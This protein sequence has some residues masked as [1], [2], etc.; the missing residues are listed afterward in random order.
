MIRCMYRAEERMKTA[1]GV[2][3]RSN[4]TVGLLHQYR[5]KK[6]IGYRETANLGVASRR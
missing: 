5:A 4:G 1:R 2:K 6:R 3:E